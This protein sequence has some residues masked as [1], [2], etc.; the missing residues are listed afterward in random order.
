MHSALR[1]R[2][3]ARRFPTPVTFALAFLG[4]GAGSAYA[5]ERPSPPARFTVAPPKDSSTLRHQSREGPQGGVADLPC[6]SESLTEN[7][8]AEFIAPSN[9]VTCTAGTDFSFENGHARPFGIPFDMFIDCVQFG[10]QSNLGN[11]WPVTVRVLEGSIDAPYES[12]LQLAAVEVVIPA[13][14]SQI[15]LVADF[16]DAA[17]FLVAGGDYIVEI[18]QPSRDPVVGGDGGLLYLGSNAAGESAPTY[19]HAPACGVAGFID[20]DAIGFPQTCILMTLGVTPAVF[21]DPCGDPA[22]GDCYSSHVAR[23]CDNA[24]CCASVCAIDPHCCSATWDGPCAALAQLNCIAS[25]PDFNADGIVNGADLATMLGAWGGTGGDL[26]GDGIVSGGDLGLLLGAWGPTTPPAASCPGSEGCWDE[27]STSGCSDATCCTTVCMIDPTCCSAA[28]DAGCVAAATSQCAPCCQHELM[29]QNEIGGIESVTLIPANPAAIVDV[30][31]MFDEDEWSLVYANGTYKISRSSGAP[32]PDFPSTNVIGIDIEIVLVCDSTLTPTTMTVEWRD[33]GGAMVKTQLVSLECPTPELVGEE[34][35]LDSYDWQSKSILLGGLPDELCWA[36]AVPIECEAFDITDPDDDDV[37]S[38]KKTASCDITTT[39]TCVNGVN[40]LVATPPTGGTSVVQYNWTVNDGTN[41]KTYTTYPAPGDPTLTY[42]LIAGSYSVVVSLEVCSDD[43]T[44]VSCVSCSDKTID[45]ICIVH[46]E[47]TASG[48]KGLCNGQTLSGYSVTLT[49]AS[50]MSACPPASF[51]WNFGDGTAA[52]SGTGAVGTQTHTYPAAAGTYY[53][54]LTITDPPSLGGCSRSVTV[55]VTITSACAPSFTYEYEWCAGQDQT[56]VDVTFTNTSQTFCGSSFVWTWGD[57][58]STTTTPGSQTT[59]THT[60]TNPPAAGTTYQV[61]LKMIDTVKCPGPGGKSVTI[62][63]KLIPIA[64]SLTATACEDGQVYLI[65]SWDPGAKP[66]WDL[67]SGCWK[68]QLWANIFN[69]SQVSCCPDEGTQQFC[70]TV[71]QKVGVGTGTCTVC[72]TVT[73]ARS[74]YPKV[75]VRG[76]TNFTV[77]AND[78]RINWRDKI[79]LVK[80]RCSTTVTG[81]TV[82]RKKV[83]PFWVKIKPAHDGSTTG[84]TQATSHHVFREADGLGTCGCELDTSIGNGDSLFRIRKSVAKFKE[85]NIGLARR[86]L[87]RD[88]LFNGV[89]TV[90]HHGHTATADVKKPI[91]LDCKLFNFTP[92]P[93]RLRAPTQCSKCSN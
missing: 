4:I 62:P 82:L 68:E 74:C 83:G 11:A 34:G 55:P 25:S 59:V 66:K 29:L 81:R 1:R 39:V 32:S 2:R 92:L 50:T 20:V 10:V 7:A 40:T 31:G 15:L 42:P 57:G 87:H 60:Y 93:D 90:V 38:A 88:T 78:Y 22:S 71:E 19:L 17:P 37:V 53:T 27:H 3:H 76:R 8:N 21:G 45:G 84:G 5:A 16:G 70:V 46:P 69:R 9:T 24:A 64:A 30:Y 52:V 67:P 49:P 73:V 79:D 48:P 51:Q 91:G 56:S 80:R 14:A 43:G 61:T 47:F 41:N 77:G 65:A 72:A 13:N 26:D 89:H 63:V 23:G 33:L 85:K 36:G 28:W 44:G 75:K 58:S 6:G 35:W 86:S 12:L 54:T 18:V